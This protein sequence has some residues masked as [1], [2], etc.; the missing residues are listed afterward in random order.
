MIREQSTG[1]SERIAERILAAPA[2]RRAAQSVLAGEM[3][4]GD[5]IAEHILQ[6]RP[7]L[8]RATATRRAGSVRAWVRWMVETFP[9]R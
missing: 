5:I 1:R 3:P 8:S 4:A 9:E 7:E 2:F 6:L